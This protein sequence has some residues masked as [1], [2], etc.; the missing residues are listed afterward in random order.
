MEASISAA[1]FGS[2][3]VDNRNKVGNE[4]LNCIRQMYNRNMETDEQLKCCGSGEGVSVIEI[5]MI[6]IS[7]TNKYENI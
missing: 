6:N 3:Q 7:D 5:K 4:S 1:E 2:V